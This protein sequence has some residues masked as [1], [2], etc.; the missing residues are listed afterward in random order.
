MLHNLLGNEAIVIGA[1]KTQRK[2]TLSLQ[3]R[4]AAVQPVHDLTI[5]HV[6]QV[7]PCRFH[8]P[9]FIQLLEEIAADVEFRLMAGYKVRKKLFILYKFFRVPP[10]ML[11]HYAQPSISRPYAGRKLEIPVSKLD[12]VRANG[13]VD[14][15]KIRD[16]VFAGIHDP[17]LGDICNIR[18]VPLPLHRK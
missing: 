11:V 16:V 1:F 14:Q 2:F 3:R 18:T 9:V 13:V 17:Y 4:F 7:S 8:A 15:I 6:V 10:P 12:W 5:G